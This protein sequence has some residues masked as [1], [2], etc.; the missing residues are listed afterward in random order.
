M[1][2]TNTKY[3]FFF[4][5]RTTCVSQTPAR[6]EQ[7]VPTSGHPTPAHAH[8]DMK[9]P[10]VKQ[11]MYTNSFFLVPYFEEENR[12]VLDLFSLLVYMQ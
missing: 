3:L 8:R 7:L 12:N 5:Q 6:M 10:T 1:F 2:T 9:E 11:V 4:S